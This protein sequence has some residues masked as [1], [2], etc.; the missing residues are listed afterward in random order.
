MI[1]EL[2]V[3]R[4]MLERAATHQ[5]AI[6][7][8]AEAVVARLEPGGSAAPARTAFT[9]AADACVECVTASLQV[10]GGY[11]YMADFGLERRFRDAHALR[12]AIGGARPSVVP[13][14]AP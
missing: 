4:G 6:A 12:P 8:L 7:L 10:L 14:A 5:Q 3:V 11:G 9:A 13:G 2:P 1:A